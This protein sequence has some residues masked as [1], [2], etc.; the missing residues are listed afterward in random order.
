MD[1]RGPPNRPRI[2]LTWGHLRLEEWKQRRCYDI[3]CSSQDGSRSQHLAS[4]VHV[5]G[6]AGG[7]TGCLF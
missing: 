3:M 5:A 7:D 6:S 2:Y 1:R 4:F